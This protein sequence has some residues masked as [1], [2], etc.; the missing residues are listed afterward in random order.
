MLSEPGQARGLPAGWASL[1]RDTEARSA[2]D[3]SARPGRQGARGLGPL[4]PLKNSSTWRGQRRRLRAGGGDALF[5]APSPAGRWTPPP[6]PARPGLLFILPGTQRLQEQHVIDNKRS[7]G[8]G[9]PI[10][11]ARKSRGWR[12]GPPFK[13]R[14]SAPAW[15]A[16]PKVAELRR[17]RTC[18][19]VGAPRGLR[20]RGRKIWGGADKPGEFCHL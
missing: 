13:I 17:L 11:S 9:L 12:Q 14:V 1:Q 18:R 2:Q 4:R 15:P 5:R 20:V 16:G 7:A 6:P 3:G 8:Q 10:G 19:A